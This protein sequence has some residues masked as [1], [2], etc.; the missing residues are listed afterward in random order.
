MPTHRLGEISGLTLTYLNKSSTHIPWSPSPQGRLFCKVQ[1][2]RQVVD[3]RHGSLRMPFIDA[4]TKDSMSTQM[5]AA[6]FF[7]GLKKYGDHL[8]YQTIGFV[9]SENIEQHR[10][11]PKSTDCSATHPSKEFDKSWRRANPAHFATNCSG[12]PSFY[13]SKLQSYFGLPCPP[14]VWIQLVC[15]E[16]A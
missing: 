11:T 2:Q 4:S 13:L 5:Y 14:H 1:W 8:N 3:Q 16:P 12:Y 7:H 9:M 15:S 10:A 6:I